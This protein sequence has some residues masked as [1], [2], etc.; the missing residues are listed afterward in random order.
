MTA[1]FDTASEEQYWTTRYA[2]NQTGWDIG[3]AAAP[4]VEYAGQLT[5]KNVRILIP[6]AGNAWEAE[7]LFR[8]G[9]QKVTVLDISGTPLHAFAARVPEF[10][11]TQL[12]CE[13]FFEHRAEY[14]LILE[15]TFFCS[16]PPLPEN[17]AAY[18]RKMAELL[19]PGGKL[20][21]L[22]FDIP[23]GGDLIKRPFGGSRA[24][25]LGYLTPYFTVKTFAPCYNSI[26]PRAGTELFGIFV[27]K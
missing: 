9:F 2:E 25:Y 10:P 12:V 15:Q 22:W 19:R 17:R 3:S 26:P 6:G 8:A 16:F 20:V 13:N 21:G 18:A 23:L 11:A 5:D 24:E 14:D 7:H 1:L 27:R 4:I